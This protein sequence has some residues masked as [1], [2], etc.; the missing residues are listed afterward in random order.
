MEDTIP[1]PLAE[2]VSDVDYLVPAYDMPAG[3]NMASLFFY[4]SLFTPSMKLNQLNISTINQNSD[5]LSDS[6]GNTRRTSFLIEDENSD[7]KNIIYSM[8]SYFPNFRS[9]FHMKEKLYDRSP[10]L[11]NTF[12]SI[13]RSFLSSTSSDNYYHIKMPQNRETYENENHLEDVTQYIYDSI[14]NRILNCNIEV[15]QQENIHS[16]KSEKGK[17]CTGHCLGDPFIFY[18]SHGL[19]VQKDFPFNVVYR[20]PNKPNENLDRFAYSLWF[21]LGSQNQ[22]PILFLFFKNFYFKVQEG[23][24]ESFEPED[25]FSD[26]NNVS[27]YYMHYEAVDRNEPADNYDS[28]TFNRSHKKRDRTTNSD[29]FLKN[30]IR[31]LYSRKWEVTSFSFIDYL[32]ECIIYPDAFVIGSDFDFN[33]YNTFISVFLAFDNDSKNQIIENSTKDNIQFKNNLRDLHQSY[34][35]FLGFVLDLIEILHLLNPIFVK[36]KKI[37]G[38]S[39]ISFLCYSIKSLFSNI[40]SQNKYISQ[41]CIKLMINII[42][43]LKSNKYQYSDKLVKS[44]LECI[45]TCLKCS[46]NDFD[47]LNIDTTNI[48]I[49]NNVTYKDIFTRINRDTVFTNEAINELKSASHHLDDLFSTIPHFSLENNSDIEYQF[50]EQFFN[51]INQILPLKSA[52]GYF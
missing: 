29:N 23:V 36:E 32:I 50:S 17:K 9:K 44:A 20:N 38:S 25:F 2:D 13:S 15:S 51:H 35:L 28:Y 42:N 39:Q 31:E 22:I 4:A 3:F 30:F 37:Q 8:L 41:M 19:E 45:C 12:A 52:I 7:S 43:R 6:R 40:P 10:D 46:L 14:K 24:A 48:S 16:S 27:F 21:A 47:S 49:L 33:E 34:Q 26:N 1:F 5:Y 11:F 18:T